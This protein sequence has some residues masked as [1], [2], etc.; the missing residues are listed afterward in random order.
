MIRR[1]QRRVERYPFSHPIDQ[2]SHATPFALIISPL[3]IGVM[4]N[5]IIVN[6]L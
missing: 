5:T 4:T 3:F 6:N 2:S 1:L